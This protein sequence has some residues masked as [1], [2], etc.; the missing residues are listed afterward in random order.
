MDKLNRMSPL[1]AVCLGGAQCGNT[2]SREGGAHSNGAPGAGFRWLGMIAMLIEFKL[3]TNLAAD[4][5]QSRR[6][7]A[8]KLSFRDRCFH[9]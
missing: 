2:D 9:Q 4:I 6:A 7:F 1:L 8:V 3:P 5:L